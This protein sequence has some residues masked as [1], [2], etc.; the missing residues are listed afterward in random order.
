MAAYMP[1]WDKRIIQ[2]KPVV[3]GV[4]ENSIDW[5]ATDIIK[6]DYFDGVQPMTDLKSAYDANITDN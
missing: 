2:T 6:I 5:K 4:G 1:L 3:R